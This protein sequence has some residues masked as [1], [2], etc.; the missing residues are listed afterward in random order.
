MLAAAAEI[1]PLPLRSEIQLV[2]VRKK[3]APVASL[4]LAVSPEIPSVLKP[5]VFPQHFS[6]AWIAT[7]LVVCLQ[8]RSK[9]QAS[10]LVASA[11]VPAALAQKCS[12]QARMFLGLAALLDQLLSEARKV[13]VLV[14]LPW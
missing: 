5:V 9:V 2:L 8:R 12:S 13:P 14:A 11:P 3:A 6:M 7:V 4:A 10:A 1:Y